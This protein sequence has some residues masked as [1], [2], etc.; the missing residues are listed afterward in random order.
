[1]SLSWSSISDILSSLWSIQ[2]LNLVYA[3]QSSCV[4]FFSSIKSFILFLKL[5]ILINISSNLFSRFLV[6]LHWVRTY[7][8]SSEKFVI[9]HLLK[10]V[11][12][13]SSE[14]FSIQ[15]CS[16]AGEEF[17]PLEEER[18]SGFHPFCTG[19]FPFLWIYLPVVFV[20]GDFQIGYLHGC[21][22]C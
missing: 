15:L 18:H 22:F 17:D 6:S 1:M 7:S 11:S 16:L 21:P 14:S 20:V 13:N 5:F 3:S 10:P 12:V 4:V 19:F 9:T 8:F 2:L